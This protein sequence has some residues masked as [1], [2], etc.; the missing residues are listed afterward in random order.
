M[1]SAG[2]LNHAVVIER[3]TDGD[4]DERGVPAQTWATLTTVHASV[5]P[6]T[7]RDLEQ[8]TQ[9]GPVA[10]THKAYLLPTDI[11]Q[12]DRLREGSRVLEIDEVLDEAGAGHH[13]KLLLHEVTP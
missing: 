12:A 9:G 11:T 6:L 3:S 10:A 5:Q 8:L 13:L 2:L 4:R 7:A 1:I